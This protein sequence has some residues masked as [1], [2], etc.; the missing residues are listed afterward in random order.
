MCVLPVFLILIETDLLQTV[1]VT[2]DISTMELT[3]KNAA[4]S[5]KSVLT[6]LKIVQN[7]LTLV[8]EL[9]YLIVIVIQDISIKI[10]QFV[11][12]VVSGVSRV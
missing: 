6:L 12:Y 10:S 9:N 3:V 1:S 5:V 4:I 8:S 7:A 2:Q 11:V